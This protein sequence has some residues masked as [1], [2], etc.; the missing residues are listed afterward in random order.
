MIK[1]EADHAE[2]LGHLAALAKGALVE[3]DGVH[4]DTVLPVG[5]TKAMVKLEDG[6]AELEDAWKKLCDARSR[7]AA[8]QPSTAT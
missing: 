7:A 5:F 3:W 8:K 1:E 4:R 6:V 2:A